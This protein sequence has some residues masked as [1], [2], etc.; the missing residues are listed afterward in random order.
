[1]E[2]IALA[3]EFAA[4]I[5]WLEN[6]SDFLS[7][8]PRVSRTLELKLHFWITPLVSFLEAE[9]FETEDLGLGLQS[10]RSDRKL[11]RWDSGDRGMGDGVELVEEVDRMSGIDGAQTI[12]S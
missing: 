8:G 11:D 1:M 2:A 10:R 12:S 6:G 5:D 3:T 4:L 7:S 9:D